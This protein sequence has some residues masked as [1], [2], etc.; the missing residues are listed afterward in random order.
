M[1]IMAH[2]S[3]KLIIVNINCG[4]SGIRKMLYSAIKHLQACGIESRIAAANKG[5]GGGTIK[6][7]FTA[8]FRIFDSI[9]RF[10]Y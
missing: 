10:A 1:F 5:R 7:G 8:G 2:S 4:L 3:I 6:I 9:V